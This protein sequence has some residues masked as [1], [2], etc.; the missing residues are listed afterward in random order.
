MYIYTEDDSRHMQMEYAKNVAKQEAANEYKEELERLRNENRNLRNSNVLLK[1]CY[2][3]VNKTS[4]Y[5]YKLARSRA[6]DTNVAIEK[7]I[8]N[9]PATVVLWQDG[10]KTVVKAQNDEPF[11]PEKGLAMAITKKVLGNKGSYYDEI[12]KWVEPYQ[13][14]C[15][16]AAQEF[17][18]LLVNLAKELNPE[19]DIPDDE[20]Q[21]E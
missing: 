12:K 15:E 14:E 6:S 16:D 3:A 7:V 11:D 21:S 5:W 19:S 20:A 13:K 17:V 4:V 9:Q 2:E 1:A 10:T 18:T 8:F